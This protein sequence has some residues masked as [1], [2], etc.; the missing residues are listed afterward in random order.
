MSII[1]RANAKINL[2]LDVTA[3]RKN[4]YHDVKTV[5]QSV[6]LCDIL[7]VEKTAAE[8]I[9]LN[10]GGALPADDSNLIV[11]AAKCYFAASGAPFGVHVTLQKHIPM[12]AGMGGGSADAAATLRAL[13]E[14][15]GNRFTAEELAEMGA[16]IGADVP[17]CVL[18]GTALCEGIGEVITPITTTLDAALVVAM[19]NEG[20]STPQAFAA[21][22]ARYRDFVDFAPSQTPTALINALQKGSLSDT[23]GALFNRFEEVVEPMRPAVSEIKRSLLEHGALAAQMSGS[24][25]SVFGIFENERDAERAALALK[26]ENVRAYSCQFITEDRNEG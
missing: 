22:D 20:V 4:G 12:A 19:G 7:T 9:S 10:T 1:V 24:G 14:L 5:M 11:R 8:A 18:G 25:P 6:S 17:F 23:V 2:Y 13:N 21:L 15:D 26:N 16:A 3:K